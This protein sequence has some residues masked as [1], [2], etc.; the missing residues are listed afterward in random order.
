MDAISKVLIATPLFLRNDVQSSSVHKEY[1]N[2]C[3]YYATRTYSPGLLLT[4]LSC[5]VPRFRSGFLAVEINTRF[6]AC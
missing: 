5:V 4:C 3:W 1:F 6:T 2:R